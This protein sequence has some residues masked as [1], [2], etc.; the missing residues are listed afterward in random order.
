MEHQSPCD[1][2]LHD[3]N[4]CKCMCARLLAIRTFHT[5]VY[6][7]IFPVFKDYS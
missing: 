3:L 6:I 2:L 5:L 7:D 4:F 1:I